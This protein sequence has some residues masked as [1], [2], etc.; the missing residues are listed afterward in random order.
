MSRSP[1]AGIRI[2]DLTSV[3]AG[4]TATLFLADY[5]AEV[6]KIEPPSGEAAGGLS[7]CAAARR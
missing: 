1:L 4:P 2:L 3:E 6:I 5:R 7:R